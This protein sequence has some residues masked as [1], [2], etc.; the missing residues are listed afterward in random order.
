MAESKRARFQRRWGQ[1]KSERTSFVPIW[2]DVRDF[3]LPWACR[4]EG[5]QRNR[6][7]RRDDKIINSTATKA[8]RTQAA[9]M[10][11][12]I[13]SP[14]RP[15]HMLTT[16]DPDLAEFGPVKE[17]LYAVTERQRSI[18]SR[19]NFYRAMPLMYR[20]LGGFAT[21]ATA[22]LEDDEDGI[23]CYQFPVGSY[24]LGL[25]ERGKV[26]TLY[27]E[28]E[29]TVRQLVDMFG[30]DYCSA[31]VVGQYDRCQYD[32]WIKVIHLIEPNDER[33]A[34]RLDSRNKAFR[35]V[36]FELGGDGDKLLRESGFDRFVVIAPRWETTGED[37]Y[38]STCP[39]FQCLGDVKSLQLKERRGAQALDKLVNP[40]MN[41]DATLRNTRASLLPGDVNYIAGFNNAASGGFRPA[42]EINPR[43]LE[44]D[45]RILRDEQR[46]RE[47]YFEDLFLMLAESDRRQ[48]TAREIDE[49]HEEKLIALGPVLESVHDEALDPAID[50]VYGLQLRYSQPIW[51]GRLNPT[52]SPLLIPPP[53]QELQGVDLRVEYISILA[54]A[55]K[56]IGTKSMERFSSFV[57]NLAGINPAV[58]DK[59]DFDQAVDE[60][61]SA[62]GVNPRIVRTDEQ[63]A[64][65]RD[66]RAQKE[67]AAEAMAMMQQ[68]TQGA[69]LLSETDT[70]SNNALTQAMGVP[71]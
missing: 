49:R 29:M 33:E 71:A 16:P 23:R 53:P 20:D 13:T 7:E 31:T 27:R 60:Y 51:E 65:I 30:R 44:L 59:L 56:L 58:I 61:A 14:A 3:I 41:A 26:D 32:Q 8:S 42:Y 22:I 39:G 67:Q 12:G 17:W 64:E 25:N 57:G 6:G 38:G 68:A 66:Q 50:I 35:S 9:G 21:H 70:A 28:L 54:Q 37:I 43:L 40:P 19:S 62:T 55:Q 24:C 1:L 47:I 48:I 34:G 46:I 5:E 18:F 63:V 69:K 10:T 2:K 15:W 4:F 36:Y 11:A 52:H 45:Q